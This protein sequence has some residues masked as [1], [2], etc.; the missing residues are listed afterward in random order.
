MTF[1]LEALGLI[2][3]P[4]YFAEHLQRIGEHLV[5]AGLGVLFAALIGL[6]VGLWL[7]HRRRGAS[8][9]LAV[10]GAF[11]ALPSL[12]LLTWLTLELSF[13]IRMPVVPT[14]I[15]LLLLGLSPILANSF[16]GLAS[17]PADVVDSARAVGHTE[18]QILRQVELP[19]AAP[20]IVGGLRSAVVQTMAT[21]T[22][23]AYIGLG[24]LGR[25]LLDGLAVQDY[26]RMLAGALLIMAVTLVLDGLLGW[27]QRVARPR[28]VTA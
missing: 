13:G 28:G 22:V 5:L 10:S 1:L 6:P 3:D 19:L 12:G 26:A 25:Y 24:G 21:T 11:R 18:A 8:A 7:G 15:V 4:A 14:T 9:V 27:V 20:T 16:S 23:A 17:V 2:F